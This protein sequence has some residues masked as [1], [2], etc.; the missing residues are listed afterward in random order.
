MGFLNE[1]DQEELRERFQSLPNPVRLL[2]FTQEFECSYCQQTGLLLKEVA[3][4]SDK[5]SLEVYNFQLDREKVA[6]YGIDKI[7]AT[8]VAGDRDYGVRFYGI[9]AGYEFVSF[10]EAIHHVSCRKSELNPRTI[11]ALRALPAPVHLQVFATPT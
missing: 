2:Y 8:V 4:L 11:A 6:E 1:S 3:D 7:P 5:I 10:I 9:P